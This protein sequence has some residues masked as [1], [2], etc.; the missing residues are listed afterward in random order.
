MTNNTE[1]VE[2]TETNMTEPTQSIA[3]TA[4][5]QT[6]TVSAIAAHFDVSLPTI[7]RLVDKKLITP[8]NEKNGTLKFTKSNVNSYIRSI[9]IDEL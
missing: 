1:S 4:P 5:E 6:Y 9:N 3:E 7:Y 8:I 2:T